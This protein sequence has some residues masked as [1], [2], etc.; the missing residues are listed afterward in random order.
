MKTSPSHV[1][2]SLA[3][4]V[5]LLLA[6]VSADC[7]TT[8][9]D[10]AC[11]TF[12]LS[13]S[14]INPN[15]SALCD[16]MPNMPGC[17][18]DTICSAVGPSFIT[19]SAYC[20]R[21]VILKTLCDDMGYCDAYR[22]MCRAGSV[23]AQCNSTMLPLPSRDS[24]ADYIQNMCNALNAAECNKCKDQNGNFSPASCDLLGVYSDLC[25]LS[26][27]MAECQSWRNICALNG[28]N[29]WP[30]CGAQVSCWDDPTQAHCANYTMPSSEVESSISILCASMPNMPGCT[31]NQECQD[32]ASVSDSPY[33]N[34][35]AVLKTICTD[36][37]RMR[38]CG[39]YTAICTTSGSVVRQCSTD[40]LIL[41]G[42]SNTASMIKSICSEMYMSACERCPG[43]NGPGTGTNCS[44]ITVYSDLCLD[45]PKM[46]Q[47]A[48]WTSMCAQNISSWAWCNEEALRSSG[49]PPMKMYFHVS[50]FDRIL[51][52]TWVTRTPLSFAGSWFI[53]FL[54]AVLYEVMKLVRKK[55]E[56]KWEEKIEDIRLN[57]P[58]SSQM[59][60]VVNEA[61]VPKKKS[62]YHFPP[63]VASIDI[64]RSLMQALEMT[65]SLMVML[66]A[67]TFNVAL[68]MAIPAG[69]L[70]GTLL[71]GRF[72]GYKAPS[73]CCS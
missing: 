16:M 32:D 35:F 60:G 46:T 40:A 15:I 47:C 70:V 7:I 37:P 12:T 53:C 5:G 14:E 3:V 24:T 18:L 9:S 26:P 58:E 6:L 41:P 59:D 50:T 33:C 57:P 51:F 66:I 56:E 8:P 20:A 62:W 67:M 39:N 63:F 4:V 1:L 19:T 23:V 13:T 28:L 45:M 61:L 31:L 10:P 11:T 72:L 29:R 73:G 55:M 43:K 71:V 22:S 69:T 48:A 49:E 17:T 36:M 68:F 2:G 52:E 38:G 54:S 34:R 27:N 44:L 21:F 64:P 42:T 65:W 30:L 25:E